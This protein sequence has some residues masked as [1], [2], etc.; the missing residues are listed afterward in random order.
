MIEVDKDCCTAKSV[1]YF[2]G[3]HFG[4]SKHAGKVGSSN[5]AQSKPVK[6]LGPNLHNRGNKVALVGDMDNLLSNADHCIGL[7]FVWPVPR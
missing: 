6:D 5:P 7:L 2:T 4:Q 3:S 1:T